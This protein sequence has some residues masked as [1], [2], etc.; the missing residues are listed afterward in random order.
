MEYDLRNAQGKIYTF[1]GPLTYQ[2][3]AL[4]LLHT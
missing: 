2:T 3:S 4:T 1:L